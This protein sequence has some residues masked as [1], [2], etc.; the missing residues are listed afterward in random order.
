MLGT[1][2]TSFKKYGN[3]VHTSFLIHGT[4]TGRLSSSGPNLQNILK[5]DLVRNHFR[6]KKG[7]ILLSFD[8][9]QAE[10]R[11]L[12][13]LSRDKKLIAAFNS[14]KDFHASIAERLW[15]DIFPYLSEY[16]ED[17]KT[18]NPVYSEFRRK[19]K[20]I[21]FGIV[22][23]LT[24]SGLAHRLGITK[25]E[26]QTIIDSWLITFDKAN[27]FL[28]KCRNSPIQSRPLTTLFGRERRFYVI[29]DAN[30]RGQENEAGNFPHQSMCSDF[31]LES[32]IQINNLYKRGQLPGN[33]IQV[34]IVHDDNMFEIDDNPQDIK[35]LIQIVKPI[36]ES[37]P[38]QH[39]ITE[40]PFKV[41]A[42]K[43]VIWSRMQKI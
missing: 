4:I 28:Q 1:Y 5:L 13:V 34:N 10:L 26:A 38:R 2:I 32:A 6:T 19:A 22:Y 8:Y 24:A 25:S 43:G 30:K 42:K 29:T 21:N 20:T 39:G 12:A 23:G 15:P 7:R 31:T 33:A 27:I 36:M 17:G 40:L 37:I 35:Q 18:E 9:S 3:R 14:G 16:L 41:D 11:S